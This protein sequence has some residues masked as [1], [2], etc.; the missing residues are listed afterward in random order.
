MV[1]R[2][3]SR[4]RRLDAIRERL[5][6]WGSP[7]A[8]RAGELVITRGS[9]AMTVLS[10][11]S[12]EHLAVH[13]LGH[14]VQLRSPAGRRY[15]RGVLVG[16]LLAGT[17]MLVWLLNAMTAVSTRTHPW[18]WASLLWPMTAWLAL[19]RV[20]RRQEIAADTFATRLVPDLAA[21]ARL[22]E[23]EG[24]RRC[25]ARTTRPRRWSVG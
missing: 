14:V 11:R 22:F 8:P 16:L 21:A 19:S 20:P 25:V 13:E 15:Q 3:G 12:L 10:D 2:I 9:S 6:S 17:G 4:T 7:A 18:P 5:G 23:F 1:A 24:R